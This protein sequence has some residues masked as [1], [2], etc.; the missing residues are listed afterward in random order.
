MFFKNLFRSIHIVQV[1]QDRAGNIKTDPDK[2]KAS[3]RPSEFTAR[4]PQSLL[5]L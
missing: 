4:R 2:A 1:L 3:Q 5:N